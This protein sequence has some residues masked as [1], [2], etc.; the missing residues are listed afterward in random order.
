M[1][2]TVAGAVG[3]GL[4]AVPAGAGAAP[5]L[6]PVSPEDLV[7]SVLSAK[8][9]PFNGTV[10]LDNALGLPPIPQLPQAANGTSTARVWSDGDHKGRLAVPTAQ[11]ERTIVA[12]GTT[13]WSW[14]S[15]DRTVTRKPE[16]AGDRTAPESAMTDP[17]GAATQAI[18]KL[19]TTSTVSVDGTAE[20]AGRPA[21]ELVLAPAPTERTLLREVRIAVD[22]Q[23][24]VPLR[25]SVLANGSSAPALQIGF[26]D[27]TFGPQDG[28]LFSF[29][30]PPGATV[31]NAPAEHGPQGQ[32][33]PP[34]GTKV[35]GDGWDA[36]V[37]G[38]V[39][40]T[41][42]SQGGAPGA[43]RG[44]VADLAGLGK[45]VSGSWGSGREITTA[46]ATAII[47]GDG[48]IAAGAVPEQVL[49][50]A[51]SK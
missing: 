27:V 10:E 31:T 41:G 46:V 36:V 50:E 49:T 5:Q 12:D 37:I 7:S 22:A 13:V 35:I 17:S 19:R 23:K 39:P 24:R 25:L 28:S 11:G 16:G 33:G 1:G 15:A 38:K 32:Q 42:G 2:V 44:N 48:R 4:L 40:T 51:L 9:G 6:P 8:P 21:Y 20:V 47:T 26:T 30:P 34:P 43:G 3:L 29:T 14:N 18:R 45:P